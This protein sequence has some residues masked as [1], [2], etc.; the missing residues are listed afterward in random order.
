MVKVS[1]L[2]SV[3]VRRYDR[4]RAD[5]LGPEE[6][7]CRADVEAKLRQ[8]CIEQARSNLLAAAAYR[9]RIWNMPGV[10]V[11]DCGDDRRFANAMWEGCMYNAHHS[12]RTA[13]AL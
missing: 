7:I 13:L 10:N 11:Y 3:W 8:Q 12:R 2:S 5:G 1:R 4:A 6:A 9:K